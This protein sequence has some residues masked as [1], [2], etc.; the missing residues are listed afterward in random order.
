[1]FNAMSRAE[2]WLQD[3][4]DQS[5]S[6]EDLANHLGYSAS[7]IRRQFRHCFNTSPSA[8]R[9]QRRLERAAVLL[10]LTPQNI[11]HIAIRCGYANHSSFSRAFQRRYQLTPRHYRQSFSSMRHLALPVKQFTTTIEKSRP[12]QAVFTRVYK[13][14]NAISGLGNMSHHANHLPC[15]VAQLGHATPT[16]ALPDLLA[17]K[18]D[19][20]EAGAKVRKSRTDIG[21]YLAHTANTENLALPVAYRRIEIPAQHY[22]KTCFDDFDE[23]SDALTSTLLQ[24]LNQQHRFHI[25]GESPRILWHPDHLELRVPLLREA[26]HIY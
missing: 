2:I 14:P 5:L 15:F 8:Y 16:V 9:E 19:A 4:L 13:A 24:L 25:S 6:I 26:T 1:M 11:A 3:T 18:V 17:D 12:R 10:S 7:Q 21:L 23:L 22:A 20:L